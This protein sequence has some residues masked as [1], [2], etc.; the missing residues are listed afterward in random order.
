[1]DERSWEQF[2]RY[3]FLVGSIWNLLGGVLIIALTGWVF[4]TAGLQPPTPPAYYQGWIALFMTF[5]IGYYMVYRDMYGN[6]NIVIL[7]MIGKFA[8]SVI[9][10]ANMIAY[11]GQVPYVFLAPVVGDL[12]F[13]VLFGMFL[14]FARRRKAPTG[15]ES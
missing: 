2:Y 12:A 7:G 8:F 11:P 14:N 15:A 13:V 10:I 4:E 5:G 1:M 9:F 6:Q 3:M